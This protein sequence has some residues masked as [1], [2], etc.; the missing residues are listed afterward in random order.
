MLNNEKSYK[1]IEEMR[2][3]RPSK[4]SATISNMLDEY[5]IRTEFLEHNDDLVD[6]LI[7]DAPNYLLKNFREVE[8]KLKYMRNLNYYSD[9]HLFAN[10]HVIRMFYSHKNKKS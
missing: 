1:N 4:K 6:S 5:R 2:R 8:G 9:L 10:L 7:A 3:Y